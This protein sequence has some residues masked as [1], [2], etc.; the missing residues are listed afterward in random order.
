M[1]VRTCDL[2]VADQDLDAVKQGSA[3]QRQRGECEVVAAGQR[4]R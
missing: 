4:L 2:A 3:V 1:K